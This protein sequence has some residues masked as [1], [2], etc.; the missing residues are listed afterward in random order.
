MKRIIAIA[1][2]KGGVGKTTSTAN[3]GSA[4]AMQGK[5]VLLIDLDAQANL[6]A[7]LVKPE[8]EPEQT[9]Y[10]AM[11][12]KT[13]SLPI[14]TIRENLDIVV[15]SLDMASIELELANKMSREFILK[16]LIEPV[17]M[18]YDYILLDCPPLLG[19]VTI[20]ALVC[21]N[22]LYIPLTAEALPT[23]GLAMLTDVLQTIKKRP[24]PKLEL[25]GIII[26]RYEN[27]KLSNQIEA[28]LRKT[29]GNSV[30]LT[31]IRKNVAIAEAPLMCTD[32]ITYAPESNG[33]KDYKLLT[34]EIINKYN[35]NGK[36]KNITR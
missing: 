3:I 14:H 15:S 34:Q 28:S 32:V 2:H 5:K 35:D 24:N 6:T 9:I 18:R 22:S 36:E 31:K 26:T 33:A 23:K 29:F 10:E 17:T 19:L 12:G 8:E 27:C 21:A 7:T 30:F 13:N 20:N 1:N 4:L 16:D 25:D 11:T